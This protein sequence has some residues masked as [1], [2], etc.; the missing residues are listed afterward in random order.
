MLEQFK[1]YNSFTN[2]TLNAYAEEFRQRFGSSVE[3]LAMDENARG[4][5]AVE[6]RQLQQQFNSSINTGSSQCN[7]DDV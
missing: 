7:N 1:M 4:I 5:V 6:R 2:A 3:A